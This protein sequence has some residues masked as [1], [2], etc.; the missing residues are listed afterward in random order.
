MVE[1]NTISRKTYRTSKLVFAAYL[2]ATDK[3]K[4]IGVEPVPNGGNVAFVL[5]PEPTESDVS[6]FFGG[7]G[8]VSARKYS[9]S[10]ATLKG[11]A[12]EARKVR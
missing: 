3:A 8:T 1:A 5:S 4:L 6:D 12:H 9:E 7:D 2:V 11:A 10:L